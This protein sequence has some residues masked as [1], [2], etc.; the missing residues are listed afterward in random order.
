MGEW[1]SGTS[2]AIGYEEETIIQW[3]RTPQASMAG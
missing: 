2:E 1:M 3:S